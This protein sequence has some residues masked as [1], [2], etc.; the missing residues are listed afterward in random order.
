MRIE[1]FLSFAVTLWS[2][3]GLHMTKSNLACIERVISEG[4]C[5]KEL[6]HA[7]KLQ[8]PIWTLQL[9]KSTRFLS[10][11]GNWSENLDATPNSSNT[12]RGTWNPTAWPVL[13]TGS[14]KDCTSSA[15]TWLLGWWKWGRR[16]VATC[17]NRYHGSHCVVLRCRGKSPSGN[18]ALAP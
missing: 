16:M 15:T 5:L 4:P 6:Q 14:A 1:H 10:V 17:P 3:R 12:S 11:F 2:S 13:A 18:V 8:D 9:R 7:S